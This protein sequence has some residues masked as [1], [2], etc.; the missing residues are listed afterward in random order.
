MSYILKIKVDESAPEFVK[1]F[2][3]DFTSHY[4]GDA[5]IDLINPYDLL[6][7]NS[8]PCET[9]DHLIQCEML[10]NYNQTVSYYLYPRSSISK[11]PLLMANSVGIIDAGYRGNIMAKLRNLDNSSYLIKSGEKLFQ[12]CAPEL[13]KINVEIVSTL[14]NSQRGTGGFGSTDKPSVITEGV[15]VQKTITDTISRIRS[16]DG[17]LEPL[18]SHSPKKLD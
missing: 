10:D 1:Q 18:P 14:S 12:I 5:G 15:Y 9:L 2:Y 6:V 7:K 17:F 4:E 11:T 3:Q 13:K 8:H 16:S